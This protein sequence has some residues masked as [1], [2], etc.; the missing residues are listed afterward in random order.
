MPEARG[1]GYATEATA[2][3]LG[4]ADRHDDGEMVCIVAADNHSS[5]RVADKVGFRSWK[6]IDWGGDPTEPTDLLLRAVGAGGPPLLAPGPLRA[7]PSPPAGE[8][9]AGRLVVIT[10]LPGSGKTSLAKELAAS[11]PAV[12]PR[13]R[14]CSQKQVGGLLFQGEMTFISGPMRR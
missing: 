5:R 3:L 11:M 7:A 9:G 10:G 12:R 1:R 4:M 13:A 8:R 2:A 6:R 14:Q